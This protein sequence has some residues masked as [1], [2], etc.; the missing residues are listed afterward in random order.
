[1]FYYG[2]LPISTT[3]IMFLIIKLSK[4]VAIGTRKYGS[5]KA[6][7]LN[8]VVWSLIYEVSSSIFV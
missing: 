7:G 5:G 4:C 6:D 8:A 1:M 2:A 3:Q